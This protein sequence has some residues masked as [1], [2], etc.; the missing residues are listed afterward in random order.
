LVVLLAGEI[1]FNLAAMSDDDISA[2]ITLVCDAHEAQEELGKRM[3]MME[4]RLLKIE[5]VLRDILLRVSL[6]G[7]ST[8]TRPAPPA[9]PEPKKRKHRAGRRRGDAR[10]R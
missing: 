4:E 10:M 5:N 7:S 2:L 9:R 8:P 6:T 1:C 3:T